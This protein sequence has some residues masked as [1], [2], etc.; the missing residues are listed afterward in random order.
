MFLGSHSY[1]NAQLESIF[2]ASV[3]G[4]GLIQL[5]HQLIA[6]KLNVL[7]GAQPNAA[8]QNAITQADAL[9]GS[10]VCPPVGSGFLPTSSTSAL[11]NTLDDF[12]NG[13]LGNSGC[14]QTGGIVP[15][16]STTW[17]RI[18]TLYR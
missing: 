5:C 4:N 7:L 16:Q 13:K 15:T 14:P 11:T 17:G 2:L 3:G 6:A 10:L 12:N 9:I 1:T 18:K 8:A